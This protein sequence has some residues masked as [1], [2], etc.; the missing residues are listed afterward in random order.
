QTVTGEMSAHFQHKDRCRQHKPDPE[1]PRHVGEFGVR[2]AIQARDLRLQRHAADRTAAGADLTY[3]G[4]HRAGV[5][6]ACG[7]RRLRLLWLVEIFCRICREF[8][9]TSG[10]AEMERFAVM[11]EAVLRRRRIDAHAADGIANL[12]RTISV[13]MVRV[14]GV[15][16]VSAAACR[17]LGLRCS[18]AAAAGMSLVA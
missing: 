8:G 5:D 17:G 1:P 11:L 12:A 10:R 2:P 7:Q 3:L 15:I 16:A 18:L 13:M 6:G 9:A 4:M 14:A